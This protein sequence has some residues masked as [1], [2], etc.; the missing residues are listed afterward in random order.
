MRSIDNRQ[1]VGTAFDRGNKAATQIKHGR[2]IIRAFFDAAALCADPVFVDEGPI[3]FQTEPGLVAEM[4][5]AV[6]QFGMVGI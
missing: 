6:A 3:D 2:A 5:M 4:Q 1:R